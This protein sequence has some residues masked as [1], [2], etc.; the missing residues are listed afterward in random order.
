MK[1]SKWIGS[2]LAAAVGVMAVSPA[3]QSASAA[4]ATSQLQTVRYTEVIRSVFY[5]PQYVALKEGFFQKYGLHVD[6]VTSQG[7]DKGAAALL[8]GTADIAL[9]GPETAIYIYNQQGDTK[10]KDFYQ[11]TTTDGSFLMSRQPVSHFKWSDLDGKTIVS[12]RPGSSPQ[13]V[14]ARVLSQHH[15]RATVITNIAAPAMV[16]AFAS[17]KGDYIQVYEPLVSSLQKSG[18]AYYVTSLG[19]AIGPYPETAYEATTDYIQ[20]HP[21]IIQAWSNAV[22]G[23]T[24][25]IHSHS[26]TQVA[27]AIATY[28]PGTSVTQLKDSVKMYEALNAWYSPVLSKQQLSLMQSVLIASH[29]EQANQAVSLDDIFVSKFARAAVQHH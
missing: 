4:M 17:G 8:S 18:E 25:W 27:S 9:V 11:L 6:M 13:M 12:W 1:Q 21:D 15:V 14:L 23:A 2:T 19:T 5:A 20:K 22:Y 3:L 24:Q 26:A 7:S 16:G 10:L 28:F 29:T